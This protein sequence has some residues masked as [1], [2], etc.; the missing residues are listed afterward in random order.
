MSDRLYK[1]NGIILKSK[2]C[3]EADRLAYVLTRERGL[4]RAIAPRARKHKSTLCGRCEAFTVG[5]FLMVNR[6]S[7]DR[8]SQI[9]IY[10]SPTRLGGNLGKL[11]AAQYW[12][13][14]VLN[15]TDEAPDQEGLHDLFLEHLRRLEALPHEDRTTW[16]AHLCQGA[17]H[18]LAVGGVAP[19]V[20]HCCV[21]QQAIAGDFDP[22]VWKVGFS[23]Q[24]GGVVAKLLHPPAGA[25]AIT[26]P[27][28][29]ARL[30]PTQL[31]C[32]QQ[33]PTSAL[34]GFP[35]SLSAWQTS[36]QL[37]R[38]YSQ[39]QFGRAIRSAALV[40]TVLSTTAAPSDRSQ[41]S[42]PSPPQ[43]R[44]IPNENC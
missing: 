38:A 4:L 36:E 14:I 6:R 43:L 33:L 26:Y 13:E 10:Q 44:T 39:Q 21:T 8:I 23:L 41:H 27:R 28:V 17:Y 3:G 11:A 42:P 22:D 34:S 29:R 30:D 20:H 1:V 12:A 16:L 37:L 9:E 18:F 24:A 15:L 31:S 35:D 40:D 32:L 5:E 2:P 19:Q 7:L 25:E